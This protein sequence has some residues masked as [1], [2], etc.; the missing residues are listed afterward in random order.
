MQVYFELHLN[1]IQETGDAGKKKTFGMRLEHLH[2]LPR[3]EDRITTLR[4]QDADVT[5]GRKNKQPTSY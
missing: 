2:L 1:I 4:V 5:R 3:N